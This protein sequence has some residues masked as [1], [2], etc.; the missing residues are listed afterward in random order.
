VNN[1]VAET[2]IHHPTNGGMLSVGVRVL[3]RLL[4][5]ARPLVAEGTELGWAVFRTHARSIRRLAQA[6]HRVTRKGEGP[7]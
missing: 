6:M 5:R 1:T 7:R 4:R 3:S 2:T